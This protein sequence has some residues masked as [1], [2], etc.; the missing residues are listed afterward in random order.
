MTT[1]RAV[2]L[3]AGVSMSTVSHVINKTRKVHPDTQRAVEQAIE[4]VGYSPNRLARA[5]AGAPTGMVGVAISALS[6]RYFASVAAAIE[7]E[8]A[9]HGLMMLLVDTHENPAYELKA[10]QALREHRVDGILIAPTADPEQ[11]T[12][13]YLREHQ[14]P[15]VLVDRLLGAGFDQ[16]A[17][18]SKQATTELV[19]HVIGLGHQR[20][21]FIAGVPGLSTTEDRLQGYQSALALA[22]M[23]FDAEL[24]RNG[25]SALEPA[26]RATHDLLALARPPTAIMTGNNLMTIGAL[27]ALVEAQVRVPQDMSLVGFDDIE[28]ADVLSPRLTVMAQPVEELGTRAVRLLLRRLAKPSARRQTIRLTPTL[29]LRDSAIARM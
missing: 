15:T 3:A 16:V 10:V 26:R 22:G 14:M 7:A 25:Q 28:W 18:E 8:C 23:A 2:A 27:R 1:M 12:L 11:R 4:Q 29:C 19:S 5:L 9:A 24:V 6:N 13:N 17:V 20:I 21:G